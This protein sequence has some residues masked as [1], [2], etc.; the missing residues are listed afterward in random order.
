MKIYNT[1]HR[2]KEKFVPRHAGEVRMY[3]CGPT[4]YN[5]FHIGNARAFLFFD[6]V[7]RYLEYRGFKVTYVQNIT[8]IEDKLIEQS[9]KE[10]KSV[11]S[12][13]QKYIKAFNEDIAALGIKK[14]D[15]QPQATQ[16]INE[17]IELIKKLEEKGV[18]YQVDGDVY[19]SV[20]EFEGYGKLSHKKL[21]ELKAGARVE[22]NK[23]KKHPADF[24]LWKKA[25]PGEPKWESPWGTGRPGWHTECV[26]MSRKLLKGTFDI[27][28]GGIDLI[29]P[30]HE[31]EIAQAEASNNKPLA[32]YWM[33]NGYLNIEGA[34]MSK[35]L[36][37]FF[38][39]RDILK[40]YD[41][42]TIRFFFLSKHYR[43]P[44]DFNEQILVESKQAVNN[45]YQ[46]LKE[47]DFL[48]LD[49]ENIS[50][51]NEQKKVQADFIAAMDDDFNTAKALSYLFEL[52]KKV[53]KQQFNLEE[54]R[55]NAK[56]LVELGQVLGFFSNIE[57]KLEQNL[58]ETA[59][60]LI[61]L[62]IKYRLEA[63]KNKNWQL[64]DKI[65]DDLK[66]LGIELHDQKE[67]TDWEIVN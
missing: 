63:K 30:H 16:Y 1:M 9:K 64:A 22:A 33:H 19:F 34:K 35:S 12:I 28:A 26:V 7:R 10:G 41:A 14:P 5:Y 13:A 15:F 21:D 32:N 45:F 46:S 59:E 40:K 8:D 6:V 36:N 48:S 20:S 62:M 56:M 53:K 66:K 39:A 25:K 67:G 52:S 17:M 65:R 55:R 57:T 43:S 27:H 3:V 60:K 4:V 2:Q 47:I 31:N 38:T 58:N 61:E 44:I 24:T 23:Q 51:T 37:N 50:Y 11:R 49:L 18:A 42:E 29:F 54:R